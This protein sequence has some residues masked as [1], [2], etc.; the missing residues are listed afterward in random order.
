MHRDI[1]NVCKNRPKTAFAQLNELDNSAQYSEP[2]LIG[3]GQ[4]KVSVMLPKY[5]DASFEG[6]SRNSSTAQWLAAKVAVDVLRESNENV[7][8]RQ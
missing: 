3:P 6:V 2:E 8:S 1:E 4:I 7:Y 5:G